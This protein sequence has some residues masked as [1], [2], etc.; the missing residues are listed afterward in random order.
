[1]DDGFNACI[2]EYLKDPADVESSFDD[3][4][5]LASSSAGLEAAE[6]TTTTTSPSV[7]L[8]SSSLSTAPSSSTSHPRPS[9]PLSSSI[10]PASGFLNDPV[11][12]LL[13][14]N[15]DLPADLAMN[16]SS[17]HYPPV[18]APSPTVSSLSSASA[19]YAEVKR[20]Q[21]KLISD[22]MWSSPNQNLLVTERLHLSS[23]SS[24]SIASSSSSS[25]STSSKNCVNTRGFTLVAPSIAAAPGLTPS[26]RQPTLDVC[27]RCLRRG[28][29]TC[30]RDSS[31]LLPA[32]STS[33]SP[34]T[35]T[36]DSFFA[37]ASS[38]SSSPCRCSP[39]DLSSL[40]CADPECK[41]NVFPYPLSASLSSSS[42]CVSIHSSAPPSDPSS[43][44]TSVSSMTSSTT[45]PSTEA[46]ALSALPGLATPSES[47]EEM[48]SISIK[49]EVVV[50][51]P[52]SPSSSSYSAASY[53]SSSSSL[54]PSTL[55]KQELAT[56]A[57]AGGEYVT[58]DHVTAFAAPAE[59]HFT[60]IGDGAGSVKLSASTPAS[61][62]S[63]LSPPSSTTSQAFLKSSSLQHTPLSPK[64]VPRTITASAAVGSPSASS[65][66]TPTRS[67]VL[68]GRTFRQGPLQSP[69]HKTRQS[70]FHLAT[71]K[72]VKGISLRTDVDG[73]TEF[74]KRK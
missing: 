44:V 74:Q 49:E 46:T 65:P 53:S 58:N 11:N 33:S 40:D 45:T 3:F 8:E 43:Y 5:H 48:E 73:L 50:T 32:T 18:S 28:I 26:Q 38:P 24:S 35:F 4:F 67:L 60:L 31:C 19:V 12:S 71:V 1:M 10:S 2:S 52:S 63:S 69:Q 20:L 70:P 9:P 47:E 41:S 30:R 39:S 42:S 61:F 72:P 29:A 64:T 17:L 62:A 14:E 55:V 25:T 56:V 7:P 66:S 59:V 15:V 37:S 51:A 23:S 16:E 57:E 13:F 36:P 54:P 22:C 21:S 34:S 68:K 27:S 6:T